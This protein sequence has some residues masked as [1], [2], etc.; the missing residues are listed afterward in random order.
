MKNMLK[1][2]TGLLLL[3]CI[4]SISWGHPL[5]G[6][7]NTTA[8]TANYLTFRGRLV[9]KISRAPIIYADVTVEGENTS[10]VSNNH[11]D[12]V[13]KISKESNAE[14]IVISHLG[15]KS[16]RV[17]IKDLKPRHNV[18]RIEPMVVPL[19]QVYVRPGPVDQIIKKVLENIGRNYSEKPNEMTGFYREA[20][21]KRKSYVSLSEAV[22]KIYK[23]PY[24]SLINDQVR[25]LKG[26][27]GS[28]VKRMDTLLFK[29]QGGPTTGLMLDLIK[30]PY[31]LLNNDMLRLYNFSLI[32]EV[33]KDNRLY[34]VVQFEPISKG[35]VPGYTGKYYIDVETYALASANFSLDLSQ[36][37]AAANLFIK[38]KPSGVKVTPVSAHYLV[39]YR[40]QN[41]KWYFNY[42]KGEVSFKIKWK[43]R[44]FS[45]VYSTLFEMVITDRDAEHAVR[46]KPR[47]RFKK[48]QIFAETVQA[49][50][51]KNYWGKYN[52]IE[53]NQSIEAAMRRFKRLLKK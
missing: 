35:G 14:K 48:N 10:T 24:E 53:P 36:P 43:K 38:K 3:L 12:F 52:Y 27:K 26:R 41:G 16:L 28:N 23:A 7:N 50:T 25:V 34:Y 39:N 11:G 42:S 19:N 33:K 37:E 15:Y 5:L 17:D 51:E 2:T 40:E 45:S 4:T 18:F 46:F 29:L 49:F 32:N 30:N 21:K 9:D 20:I 13:L 8:D 1:K 47:E 22:V 31:V 6:T 44:L